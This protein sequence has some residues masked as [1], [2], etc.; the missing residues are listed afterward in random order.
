MI[1]QNR[2]E[3]FDRNQPVADSTRRPA[4]LYARVST[5][6][7]EKEGF[8]IPAQTKL[9]RAYAEVAK[10]DVVREFVDVETAKQTGRPGFG[11]L[12]TFFKKR[13]SCRVL[14]VE[15]TDRLHRNLK[16]W[17]TLDELDVEIHF[18]KEGIVLS[19]DSRSSEKFVHG[20]KVLM[21]KNYIDNL[22]EET[23]KGM[24]EK[25]EQGIWPSVAPLGYRN[26]VGSDGKHVI[27]PDPDAAPIVTRLF[28]WYATGRYSGRELTKMAR[29]EGL[30]SRKRRSPIPPTTIYAIL[31]N[32]IYTG[33]FDWNGV[34][35]RGV[36]VPLVSRDLWER[37]Q[38]VLDRRFATKHRKFRHDF[39]FS[40]LIS[41]GHCGCSLVG[42]LK[43][44]RYVYYHCTGSKGKCPE[45]YTRQEILEE[46]FAHLLQGLHF[47][48]EVM[49]WVAQALRESHLDE[50]RYHDEAIA[51]LQTESA[52]LQNRLDS[53]YVDKLDGRVDTA[54]FD[55]KA[56]EWRSEQRSLLRAIEEHRS[57]NK[58]Y[59]DEG[60][61]LLELARRAPVLFKKQEPREKRRLLDFVV[62]NCTWKNG[63]LHASYRQP[64]D[65]LATTAQ[66]D[67]ELVAAGTR[68]TGRFENWLP[69][70]DSNQQPPG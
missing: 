27:E 30:V 8:S 69:E 23:R 49:A 28:E 44:S 11:D 56:A 29:A 68:S 16:D 2:S 4:A 37:V 13:V 54:F 48:D 64:F 46:R 61:K 66:V 20:I 26:V 33:D 67:R 43:K 15:K 65:L 42:E 22:S 25:A 24:R 36:H 57:A 35:Y 5:K 7:Q 58:T 39:A 10:L 32:R 38:E 14:L 50:R 21:A 59:L 31:R 6:E 53:M 18:A 60:V 34:T 52:R 9:L 47:D 40:G 41:C 55:Q 12:V 70:L 51:R 19:R 3:D 62:S 63:E 17:V 45:R 1:K